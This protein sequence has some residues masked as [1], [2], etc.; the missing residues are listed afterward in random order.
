AGEDVGLAALHVHFHERWHAKP[1]DQTVERGGLDNDGSTPAHL[2]EVGV[3]G[4]GLAP[5]RHKRGDGW[6]PFAQPERGAP[7]TVTDG[8]LDDYDLWRTSKQSAEKPREVWLGLERDHATAEAGKPAHPISHVR[9]KVEHQV[10]RSHKA[11]IQASQASQPQR[12]TVID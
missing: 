3:T 5:R 2:C 9:A 8:R 6:G 11:A 10:A 7:G 1:G 12:T 4:A